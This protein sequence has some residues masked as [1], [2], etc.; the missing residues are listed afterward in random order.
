VMR[1][2]VPPPVCAQQVVGRCAGLFYLQPWQVD[3]GVLLRA[4]EGQQGELSVLSSHV[5]AGVLSRD[6]VGSE[7]ASPPSLQSLA[8]PC[9][10]IRSA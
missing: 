9:Q 2:V 5:Y 8:L 7:A 10:G 6:A 4:E 3:V 1:S